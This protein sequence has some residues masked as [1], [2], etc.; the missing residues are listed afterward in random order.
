MLPNIPLSFVLD[1]LHLYDDFA[2]V[3]PSTTSANEC[4]LL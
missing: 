3:N 1:T 4:G 2:I